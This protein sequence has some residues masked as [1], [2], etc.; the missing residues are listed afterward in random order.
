MRVG[1]TGAQLGIRWDQ[2]D[3]LGSHLDDRTDVTEAHHGLCVGADQA[4]HYSLLVRRPDVRIIG[5]PPVIVNKMFHLDRAEFH[6]LREPEDYMVRNRA[7]VDETEELWACPKG[8]ETRRSGTWSTIRHAVRCHKT[9]RIF[10]PDGM[11][12]VRRSPAPSPS[13]PETATP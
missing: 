6:E 13:G 11:V 4:F 8:P 7:I 1:F 3:A 10:W 9:V 12:E 2:L 5:H